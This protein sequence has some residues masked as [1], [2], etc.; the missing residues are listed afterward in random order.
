MKSFTLVEVPNVVVSDCRLFHGGSTVDFMKKMRTI[1][2]PV[3]AHALTS[4]R[5]KEGILGTSTKATVRLVEGNPKGW[6]KHYMQAVHGYSCRPLVYGKSP[7][8][9]LYGI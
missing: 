5:K 2:Q 7:F 8:E 6:Y 9:L 4:N 3:A 1:W